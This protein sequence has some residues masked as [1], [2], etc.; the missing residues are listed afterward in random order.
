MRTHT[1]TTA[2]TVTSM[3]TSSLSLAPS[4][5]GSEANKTKQNKTKHGITK[6]EEQDGQSKSRRYIQPRTTLAAIHFRH[7]TEYGILIVVV[8]AAVV[9]YV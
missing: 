8:A 2:T 6:L 3:S 5:G 9:L 1:A 4:A 7:S